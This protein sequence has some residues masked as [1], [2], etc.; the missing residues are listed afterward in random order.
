MDIITTYSKHANQYA[1]KWNFV[2]GEKLPLPWLLFLIGNWYEI[3][4]F[5][6]NNGY[7]RGLARWKTRKDNN[8][9]GIEHKIKALQAKVVSNFI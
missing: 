2:I 7:Q 9:T 3:L 6:K 5:E 8:V 1:S 4:Q